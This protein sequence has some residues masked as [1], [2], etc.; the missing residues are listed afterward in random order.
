MTEDEMKKTWCP[1]ARVDASDDNAPSYNRFRPA[2]GI[3]AGAMCLGRQC[4]AWRWDKVEHAIAPE[5]QP[6]STW[7]DL[8]VFHPPERLLI[9]H[10]YCG[11]A[12]RP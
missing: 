6:A 1:D 8:A 5:G 11:R 2:D 9:R 4:S 3:P 7:P 12:G 10:G